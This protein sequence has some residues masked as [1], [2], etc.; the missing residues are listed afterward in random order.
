MSD[1]IEEMIKN[2]EGEYRSFKDNFSNS[3]INPEYLKSSFYRGVNSIYLQNQI[4]IEQ[5]KQI[6]KY[7]EENKK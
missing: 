5:N 2:A 6:I 4:L 7:L 3:S 1:K